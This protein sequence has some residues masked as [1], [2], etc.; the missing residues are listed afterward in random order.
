MYGLGER[1][2]KDRCT[3]SLPSSQF[4]VGEGDCLQLISTHI[5][6]VIAIAQ[7]KEIVTVYVCA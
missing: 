7:R 2:R 4:S 6:E 5:Y 1:G 3:R